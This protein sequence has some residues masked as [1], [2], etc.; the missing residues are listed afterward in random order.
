MT[1]PCSAKLFTDK[2]KIA[3][4]IRCKIPAVIKSQGLN[5]KRLNPL[6]MLIISVLS[7]IEILQNLIYVSLSFLDLGLIVIFLLHIFANLD[8]EFDLRLRA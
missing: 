1:I 4:Y 2:S 7:D 3:E 8:I 6:P 5:R